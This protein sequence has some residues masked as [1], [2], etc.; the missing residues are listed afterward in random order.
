[1]LLKQKSEVSPK[2]SQVH[3]QDIN[4]GSLNP[5]PPQFY[6]TQSYTLL[7]PSP[8]TL[9]GLFVPPGCSQ[10]KARTEKQQACG[11]Q[12]TA[13]TSKNQAKASSEKSGDPVLNTE[14]VMSW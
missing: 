9:E 1:M 13:A 2:M 3:Q 12:A 11:H 4:T 6:S 5:L 8:I 10:S 14:L 7:S